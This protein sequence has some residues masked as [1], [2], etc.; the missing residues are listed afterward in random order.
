MYVY[1]Y[2]Y[3]YKYKVTDKNFHKFIVLHHHIPFNFSKVII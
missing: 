3:M 1:L 2:T